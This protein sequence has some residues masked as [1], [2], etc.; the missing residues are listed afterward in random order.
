M[1]PPASIGQ[2]MGV[3]TGLNC[4][5]GIDAVT[6]HSEA[7]DDVARGRVPW[8]AVRIWIFHLDEVLCC[9]LLRNT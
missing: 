6:L 8:R 4:L 3:E 1:A 7:L 5:S 9:V 2:A